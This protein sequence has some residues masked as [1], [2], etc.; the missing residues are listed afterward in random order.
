MKVLLVEDDHIQARWITET[1]E[2]AFPHVKV[3]SVRTEAEFYS[4]IGALANNPPNVIVMDVMLRWT[5]PAPDMSTPPKN[6]R[7][8][9]YRRAGLRCVEKLAE[10]DDTKNI[11]VVLFTVRSYSD[12]ESPPTVDNVLYVSKE[13]EPDE[14]INRIRNAITRE[15]PQGSI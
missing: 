13:S 3:D 14:L 1:L 4:R 12:L 6:V 9:G 8:E 11:P 2:R 15:Q 7:T 5:D 10:R